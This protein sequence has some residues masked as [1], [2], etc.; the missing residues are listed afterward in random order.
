[1][2]PHVTRVLVSR[3]DTP[4][5][6]GV[7]RDALEG[8]IWHKALVEGGGVPPP[9][10]GRPAYAQPLSPWRRVPASMAFV[11]DSNRPQPLWQPP[12]TACLTTAGAASEVP[13][14]LMHPWAWARAGVRQA[15]TR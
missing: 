10:S 14:L 1:M 5:G 9:P 11:T 7:G 13:S 8:G 2:R 6:A 4:G 3:R 15:L 12:P